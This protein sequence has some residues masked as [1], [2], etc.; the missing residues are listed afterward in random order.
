M[1]TE[2]EMR[3]LAL[4]ALVREIGEATALPHW[5]ALARSVNI[6]SDLLPALMSGRI[7]LLALA[8][9]RA[10]SADEVRMLYDLIGSLITTNSLLKQ[11]AEQ[12][13][14]LVKTWANAF[15][16]L[17][18]VGNRVQQFANFQPIRGGDDE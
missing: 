15:K 9:P 18:S 17:H 3:D 4:D 10:M 6:P 2:R 16:H 8:Q 11:H 12:V 7:E 5:N 1:T 14:Q 13:S